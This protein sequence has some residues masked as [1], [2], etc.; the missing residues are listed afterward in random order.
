MNAVS[1]YQTISQ[2]FQCIIL[3]I[4]YLIRCLDAIIVEKSGLNTGF[5]IGTYSLRL[6]L[7]VN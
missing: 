6:Y 2:S 3:V 4:V 1:A 5:A 7:E